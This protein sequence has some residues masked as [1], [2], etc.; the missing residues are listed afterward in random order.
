MS[1]SDTV[2]KD[3]DGFSRIITKTNVAALVIQNC[4]SPAL[5][6]LPPGPLKVRLSQDVKA[7][8][9]DFMHTGGWVIVDP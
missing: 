2:L 4:T 5:Y 7:V 9:G 1:T 3:F 8:S 6:V